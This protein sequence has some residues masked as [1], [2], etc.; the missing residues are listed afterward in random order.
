MILRLWQRAATARSPL[1]GLV[2]AAAITG[3]ATADQKPDTPIAARALEE[4]VEESAGM[5]P[6]PPPEQAPP[7]AVDAAPAA[8][9]AES[10]A[11]EDEDAGEA[12]A[13]IAPAAPAEEK[14][15]SNPA[16]RKD[17]EDAAAI[18][19]AEPARAMVLF[20]RA[21]RSDPDFVMAWHNAGVTAER[22][23]KSSAALAYYQEAL[24]RRP[25]YQPSLFNL[26]QAYRRMGRPQEGE[27]LAQRALAQ[28]RSAGSLTAAGAAALA[29][30]KPA[31]AER[32]A[33]QA[34]KEDEKNV[35]AMLVLAEAFH[36]QRKYE[37]AKF[38]LTNA[39][40][41]SP[42]DALVLEALGRVYLALKNKP[43]A[44]KQF[45]AAVNQRQDL[46]EAY[47]N[48]AV[49]YYEL[50][51]YSGAAFASQRAVDLSPKLAAAWVNRGN[52]LRAEKR[53]PEAIAAYRKAADLDRSQHDAYYNLGILYLDNEVPDLDF[54]DR[55]ELAA[56]NLKEFKGRARLRE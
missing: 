46:V 10:E 25:D 31:D 19:A 7:P 51:D 24:K 11:E 53:Y 2:A 8:P 29:A 41:I 48:L 4:Q 23:G 30:G 56:R 22:H 3:C 6:P 42:K 54:V 33:K 32:Y 20:E 52:A 1:A 36:T 16:A 18:V 47:N 9:A 50:G 49:L 39:S 34:L 27:A 38:V 44:L 12:P 40:A 5:P 15:S 13:P 35:P 37:L 26:I 45:E 43:A 55:M 17:F 28:R 21:A 14:L